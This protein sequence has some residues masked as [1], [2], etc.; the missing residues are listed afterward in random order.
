MGLNIRQHGRV[1]P[2]A[3]VVLLSCTMA[4]G[5][6]K[7]QPDGVITSRC[8]TSLKSFERL[9]VEGRTGPQNIEPFQG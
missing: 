8:L 7:T 4:G 2:T 9:P 1:L 5:A 6:R 3:F